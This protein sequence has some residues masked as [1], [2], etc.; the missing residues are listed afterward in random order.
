[1]SVTFRPPDLIDRAAQEENWTTS[2][3]EHC[4]RMLRDAFEE[5]FQ[6][7]EIQRTATGLIAYGAPFISLESVTFMEGAEKPVLQALA[8]LSRKL[9]IA[10]PR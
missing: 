8:D 2:D 4:D 6:V 10:K 5:S 1:V 9:L 3:Q 7:K